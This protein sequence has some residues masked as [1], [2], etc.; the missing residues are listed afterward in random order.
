MIIEENVPFVLITVPEEVLPPR[1]GLQPSTLDTITISRPE[2]DCMSQCYVHGMGWRT[3][4]IQ[5]S[6][7]KGFSDL[8]TFLPGRLIPE[9]INLGLNTF[10]C[11][12]RFA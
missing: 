2:L 11:P 8:V 3:G 4:V 12:Q 1:V 9:G 10:S 6:F 5:I 7:F